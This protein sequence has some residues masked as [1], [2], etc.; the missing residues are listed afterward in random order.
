M[1]SAL[2][3]QFLMR[4][5]GTANIIFDTIGKTIIRLKAECIVLSIA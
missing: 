4:L 5:V 3:V 2:V 1:L